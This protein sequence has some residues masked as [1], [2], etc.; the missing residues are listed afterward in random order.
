MGQMV[1]G[2]KRDKILVVDDNKVN[3]VL[4]I[5]TL[6][7]EGYEVVAAAS[8]EEGLRAFEDE[9]F[10]CVILDVNMPGMDGFAA[11]DR[12]RSTERGKGLPILF[13]TALRDVDAFDRAQ[14]V[15]GDDFLTKPVRPRELA[16]R[17]RMA[18]KLKQFDNEL[19]ALVRQQQDQLLRAELQKERLMAF[20]VHDLKN[21]VNA[22]G[23]L[24][25][26][27]LRE[28]PLSTLVRNAATQIRAETHQLN[29][30]IL[31]L[32]DIA[33]SEEGKLVLKRSSVEPLGLA[34]EVLREMQVAAAAR[35]IATELSGQVR[36]VR[37]DADLIRRTL[38]NLLE[39]SIRF[40]PEESTIRV[41]LSEIDGLVEVRVIDSGP[42]IP[43]ELRQKV[44]E[45]FVQVESGPQGV[46]RL[47]RG[48]GLTFCKLAVEAHGGRIWVE[49]GTPGAVF[50]MSLP[51]GDG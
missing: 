24:A 14:A 41:I 31:N 19:V 16:A 15:G 4:T 42:G 39:N 13:L 3:R 12:I 51:A 29:R 17:V 48:L 43:V 30:L 44:F 32:L 22:V 11:C 9:R 23:L 36:T 7:G 47:N 35:G 20:V 21:P 25:Q 33:R 5:A 38:L 10:D 49:E 34:E 26:R 6:E 1:P 27:I 2:G 18:I 8:G 46:T 40:A 37:W 50:C 45:R 28:E